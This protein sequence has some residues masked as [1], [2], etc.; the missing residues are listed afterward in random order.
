MIN[1]MTLAQAL[2]AFANGERVI[3]LNP[4][5]LALLDL[6]DELAALRDP[7]LCF[8]TIDDDPVPVTVPVKKDAE[9][10]VAEAPKKKIGR[11][12]K[13]QPRDPAKA[14]TKRTN[15]RKMSKTGACIQGWDPGR[16]KALL[17]AGRDLDFLEVEFSMDRAELLAHLANS[18][19][20]VASIDPGYIHG[21]SV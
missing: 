19:M 15:N 4:I 21:G 8:M 5:N 3:V 6:D 16:A 2:A 11:P 7:S 14:Q 18:G 13:D 20:G 17:D 1:E 9:T 10:A 12:W